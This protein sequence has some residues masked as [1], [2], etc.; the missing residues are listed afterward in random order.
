VQFDPLASHVRTEQVLPEVEHLECPLVEQRRIVGD[1]R[2]DCGL[3]LTGRAD[4]SATST[5]SGA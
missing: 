2:G 5:S 3:R 1:D 4:L